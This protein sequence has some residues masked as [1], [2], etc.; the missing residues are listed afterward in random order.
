MHKV[1]GNVFSAFLVF[2][3]VTV[4]RGLDT[5][6][7]SVPPP[8]PVPTAEAPILGAKIQFATPAGHAF[9]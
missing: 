2:V 6:P 8:A 4:A 3:G 9:D 7:A 1:T 5:P